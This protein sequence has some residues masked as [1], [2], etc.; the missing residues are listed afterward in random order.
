MKKRTLVIG[1]IHGGYKA[2]VQLLERAIVTHNDTLIFLGD[3]VDGW[4]QSSEVINYL[5]KL[6]EILD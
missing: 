3:Y 6:N 1:D 4:S 2:L 5:I